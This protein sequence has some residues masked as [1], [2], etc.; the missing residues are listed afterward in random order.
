MTEHE[1]PN[2][3]AHERAFM[4]PSGEIAIVGIQS[5]DSAD[6]HSLIL[7]VDCRLVDAS[8]AS[9]TTSDGTA[10]HLPTNAT[11]VHKDQLANGTV[12][13]EGI[14]A[15]ETVKACT[16]IMSH[17]VGLRAWSKIPKVTKG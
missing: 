3:P 6:P 17:A 5:V 8:G 2:L 15:D 16:R 13:V 10:L 12:T 7:Q 14:M 11:T 9:L 1:M 4:L